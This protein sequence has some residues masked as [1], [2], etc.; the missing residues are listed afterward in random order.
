MILPK[1][2]FGALKKIILWTVDPRVIVYIHLV[3][4]NR[5]C[6]NKYFSQYDKI[7]YEDECARI[8]IDVA[9]RQIRV[10]LKQQQDIDEYGDYIEL[11]MGLFDRLFAGFVS[12]NLFYNWSADSA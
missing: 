12:Y 10:F 6:Y 9:E 3:M 5:V 11:E 8:I 7:H 4:D 1:L 2:F